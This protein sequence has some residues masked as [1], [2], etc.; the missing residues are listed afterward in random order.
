MLTAMSASMSTAL[1]RIMARQVCS[2][3]LCFAAS[4]LREACQSASCHLRVRAWSC[5][6]GYLPVLV[7]QCLNDN[8]AFTNGICSRS[9]VC[10][11]GLRT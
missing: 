4:K 8:A 5:W 9:F 1:S 6:L 7:V 11:E 10:G 3:H 2:D